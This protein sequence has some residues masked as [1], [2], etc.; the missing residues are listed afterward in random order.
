[1][2]EA[3]KTC[4]VPG[5]PFGEDNGRAKLT[6]REVLELRSR[7]SNAVGR[8]G[9][10]LVEQLANEFHISPRQCRNVIYRRSWPH[11]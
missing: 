1:M 10:Q 2:T 4:G 5:A 3:A 11:I 9:S 6:E 8:R 7:W